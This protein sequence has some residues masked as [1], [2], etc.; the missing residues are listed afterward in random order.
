VHVLIDDQ[1]QVRGSGRWTTTVKDK[2][3]GLDQGNKDGR[4][5]HGQLAFGHCDKQEY[6]RE[7]D[8]NNV[9]RS[10]GNDLTKSRRVREY[11]V[12]DRAEDKRD[13]RRYHAGCVQ[14]M[15]F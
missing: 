14:S 6:M 2:H 13:T 1:G 3:R 9:K 8:E 12:I 4:N 10:Q 11:L 5:N 7:R 15:Q